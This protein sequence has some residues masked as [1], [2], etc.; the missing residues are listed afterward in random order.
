MDEVDTQ[1]ENIKEYALIINPS[2]EDNDLLDFV[3]DSVVERALIFMNRLQLDDEDVT[4]YYSDSE[5]VPP[6]L[7]AELERTL[8][9]VVVG[10]YRNV[11][12]SA[13]AGREVTSLSDN[14]QSISYSERMSSYLAGDETDIFSSS[15]DML[16]KYRLPTIIENKSIF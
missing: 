6:I 2:L 15:L 7:P 14:G 11:T 5:D 4:D 13:T 16:K 10:A 12:A 1:K 9:Q 8:A 3:I